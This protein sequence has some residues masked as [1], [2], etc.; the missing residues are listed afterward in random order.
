MNKQETQTNLC[1]LS[2]N[3]SRLLQVFYKNNRSEDF[4]KNLKKICNEIFFFVKFQLYQKGPHRWYFLCEYYSKKIYIQNSFFSK[5][6]QATV[7]SQ[8]DIIFRRYKFLLSKE[9][10]PQR[11]LPA[12][13]AKK[14]NI[15]RNSFS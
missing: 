9:N 15:K 1:D 10:H 4:H 7:L 6:F 3:T 2:V 12:M 8:Y 14:K 13:S 5:H 11:L